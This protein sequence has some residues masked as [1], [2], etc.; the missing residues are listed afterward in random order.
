MYAQKLADIVQQ[1]CPMAYNA[2]EEHVLHSHTFSRSQ[3]KAIKKLLN[4]TEIEND[5]LS[6]RELEELRGVFAGK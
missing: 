2:F 1:W 6:K 5:S 4:G 3:I